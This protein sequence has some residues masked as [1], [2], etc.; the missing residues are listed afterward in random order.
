[1]ARAQDEEG[2]VGAGRQ[3]KV[4]QRPLEGR[5]DPWHRDPPW[6]QVTGLQPV[7]WSGRYWVIVINRYEPWTRRRFTLMHEFKHIVDHGHA[8]QLYNGNARHTAHEQA[9][10]AADY[11]AGCILMPKRLLKRAW[12][13]GLQTPTRLG[14]HFGVSPQAA[15]VRLAQT[16]LSLKRDRCSGVSIG[17]TRHSAGAAA[18]LPRRPA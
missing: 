17:H 4:E 13:N 3:V 5:E 9:E 11:F 16:G 14:R 18:P 2:S 7:H 12:C 8:Q 6:W 10:M 15:D 1:M